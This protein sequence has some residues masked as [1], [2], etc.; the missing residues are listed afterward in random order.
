VITEN[1]IATAD[2]QERV[3]YMRDHLAVVAAAIRD[4]ID[5]RG[6]MYWSAFDN[7]EWNEGYRPQFGIVGIDRDDGLRREV[8]ASARAYGELA[9]TR[10]LHVFEEAAE[11][12]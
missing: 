10:S 8:R 1:G 12:K 6:F 2:D 11:G 3:A 5:V 9:R 7:F 4:G